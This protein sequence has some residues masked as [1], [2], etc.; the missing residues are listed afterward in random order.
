MEDDPIFKDALVRSTKAR[1]R[2][3]EKTA[4][5][6]RGLPEDQ[7]YQLQYQ[8]HKLGRRCPKQATLAPVQWM[9]STEQLQWDVAFSHYDHLFRVPED[10]VASIFQP[11]VI[12]SR[13]AKQ[14]RCDIEA[15]PPPMEGKRCKISYRKL[16][17]ALMI[18]HDWLE[19]MSGISFE[20]NSR[21]PVSQMFASTNKRNEH[22]SE[23]PPHL[24][25]ATTQFSCMQTSVDS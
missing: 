25:M 11:G 7:P 2:G 20:I 14:R 23:A 24:A 21:S 17:A 9:E 12:D 18:N 13:P 8:H 19:Q 22:I 1:T 5:E 10:Q 3:S 16:A 4:E 15:P 6:I